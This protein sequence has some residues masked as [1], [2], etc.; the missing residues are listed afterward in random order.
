MQSPASFLSDLLSLSRSFLDPESSLFLLMLSTV[1]FT[2]TPTIATT[3]HYW[4]PHI[5]ELSSNLGSSQENPWELERRG[6]ALRLMLLEAGLFPMLLG[7][8]ARSVTL[9]LPLSGRCRVSPSLA[10]TST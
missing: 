4:R 1:P 2:S 8:R 10:G 9:R 6:S 7:N 3:V 5:L